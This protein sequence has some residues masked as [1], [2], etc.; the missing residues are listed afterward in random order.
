MK[1][2]AAALLCTLL[3][4]SHGLVAGA[5]AEDIQFFPA[6]NSSAPQSVRVTTASDQM[7]LPGNNNAVSFYFSDK[8]AEFTY[9]RMSSPLD[10]E[11]SRSSAGILIS[12]KRDNVL[13]AQMLIDTTPAAVDGLTLSFGGK[14]IAGLL[15]PE[16]TDVIGFALSTGMA[17][18]LPV[19]TLPLTLD[20]GI[21]YAPDVT[22]FGQSDRIID[23]HGRVRF[24]LSP[25]IS[26]FFG[27]RYLQFDTRPGDREIDKRIHAGFRWELRG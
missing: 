21:S 19:E 22:T 18:T 13:F 24:P 2:C 12:E 6:E 11:N 23:M 10:L 16:N 9:E 8:V 17:Y 15:A 5:A 4:P 26:G 1:Q 14:M 25:S 3:L 20:A 7:V 27:L